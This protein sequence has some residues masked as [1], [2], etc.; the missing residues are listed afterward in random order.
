VVVLPSN[1][2]Q[3]VMPQGAENRVTG[4]K[5]NI[6]LARS[7]GFK[8]IIADPILEPV[9][10]PGLMESLR[11]YQRFRMEDKHTPVLF[12][13][14]NVT[15]LID[16]DSGGVN[17]LLT[18]LACELGAD[19]LF[20][21]EHSPKT[22]GSVHE[23]STASKMMFLAKKRQTHPKDLGIQLL[24]LK[25][26]RWVE[27]AYEWI[28]E[29]N[30]KVVDG[31]LNNKFHPDSKGWF[32]IK[33]DRDNGLLIAIHFSHGYEAP[34]II[35]RGRNPKE[36]YQT[37][38]GNGLIDEYNHAAYLGMELKKAELALKLGKSYVQDRPLFP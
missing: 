32:Q 17:G 8:K 7:L 16:V 29:D 22:K 19:L 26:K 31:S 10:I 37:I 18:A 27:E 21:P 34:N 12:G 9:L 28:Y 11:G 5:E 15:E 24:V 25:D 3:G 33:I 1:I 20:I 23:T 38:I 36:V 6:T 35:I 4:L 14:G 13:L 30:I 2:K